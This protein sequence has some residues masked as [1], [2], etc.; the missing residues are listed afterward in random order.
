MIDMRTYSI[1]TLE[2]NIKTDYK[3]QAARQGLAVAVESFAF[4]APDSLTAAVESA[5]PRKP[6]WATST[7]SVAPKQ[8]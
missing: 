6:C 1:Y 8:A 2:P 3:S 4:A 7:V 5:S